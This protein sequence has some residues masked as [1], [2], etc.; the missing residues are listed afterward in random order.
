MPVIANAQW[1]ISNTNSI[2]FKHDAD[3]QGGDIGIA[4]SLYLGWNGTSFQTII[5]ELGRVSKYN[6]S[7]ITDGYSLIGSGGKLVLAPAGVGTVTSIT[8]NSPLTGGTITSTGTVD[9]QQASAS[10]EGTVTTVTQ[11]FAGMKYF[12]DGIVAYAPSLVEAAFQVGAS[13]G[14]E[15]VFTTSGQINKVNGVEITQGM[16]LKGTS[17]NFIDVFSIGLPGDL[18]HVNALGTDIEYFSPAYI[19]L[20]DLSATSPLSYNSGT[21]V[22]SLPVTANQILYGTGTSVGSEAAF[23]YDPSNNHLSV[24]GNWVALGGAN[25]ENFN[26]HVE[27]DARVEGVFSGYSST[28]TVLA[29]RRANG[30][31][32]MPTPILSSEIIGDLSWGGYKTT[33]WST[34]SVAAIQAVATEDYDD[35]GTGTK[36]N[37]QT[38]PNNT[39]G[40]VTQVSIDQDGTVAFEKVIDEYNNIALVNDGV[41][42]QVA[43]LNVTARASAFSQTTLYTAP[44]D[45]FYRLSYTA[46]VTTA[47][48]SSSILGPFQ[49]KFTEA[50]DA[51]TVT[52]PPGNTNNVNQTNVNSTSTGYI[53][54]SYVIHA[55]SGTDI[56]YIMG[57]ATSGAT[58]MQYNFHLI[59]EALG[60]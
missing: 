43:E 52:A 31:T 17:S 26:F 27:E 16:L 37:L 58:A 55:K 30:T 5:D 24:A 42:Y 28:K 46:K 47:A 59:L 49:Y 6:G 10:N 21:G 32:A 51:V 54:G 3:A 20:T 19:E 29:I 13:G 25:T 15:T 41:P 12:N 53:S 11:T 60:N 57:Y 34:S 2:F 39:T 40:V 14:S 35:S 48:T 1:D 23:T 45:G 33:A 56:K 4:D 36:L 50:D 8:F 44:A 18:I 7:T 38:T 9:I 22:F